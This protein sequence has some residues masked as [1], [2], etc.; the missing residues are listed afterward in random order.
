MSWAPALGRLLLFEAFVSGTAKGADHGDDAR[1]A[2]EA[3]ERVWE[4]SDR[5]S[6]IDESSVFSLIGAGALRAGLSDDPSILSEP[7]L[8]VKV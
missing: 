5:V 3:F 6:A 7:C 8:V 2:L 4:T 1:L